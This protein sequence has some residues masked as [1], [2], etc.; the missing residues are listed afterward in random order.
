MYR[1]ERYVSK[2]YGFS[3]EKEASRDIGGKAFGQKFTIAP[4]DLATLRQPLRGLGEN[5]ADVLDVIGGGWVDAA[6]AW[7]TAWRA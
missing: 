1:R 5:G 7:L 4:H 6:G 3:E 2:P